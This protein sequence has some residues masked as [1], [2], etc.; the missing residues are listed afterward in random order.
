MTKRL[1]IRTL[2]IAPL[3]AALSGCVFFDKKPTPSIHNLNVVLP[4]ALEGSLP[5]KSK[6]KVRLV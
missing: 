3:I 6:P 4:K 2:L 1:L 5:F